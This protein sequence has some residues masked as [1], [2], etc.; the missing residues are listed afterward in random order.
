LFV[1]DL[2]LLV[3]RAPEITLISAA[4]LRGGEPAA[5]ANVYVIAN[6]VPPGGD[7]SPNWSGALVERRNAT[8]VTNE[9]GIATVRQTGSG[10]RLRVVAV[11]DRFGVAVADAP[12]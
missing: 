4:T 7:G 5:G 2:G 8:V 12:L 9:M 6:P 10:S 3:K 1:T 11:S